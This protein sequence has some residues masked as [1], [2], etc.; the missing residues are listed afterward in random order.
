MAGEEILDDAEFWAAMRREMEGTMGQVAPDVLAEMAR[1]MARAGLD[2]EFDVADVNVQA[3][4]RSYIDAWWEAIETTT[5]ED[6]RAAFDAF[7]SGELGDREALIERLGSIFGEDR[8]AMIAAT[9]TTRLWTEGARVTMG[10][11]GVERWQYNTVND[12][13]VDEECSQYDG[14]VFDVDDDGAPWPPLHPNCRCF[15]SPVAA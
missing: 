2:V 10:I 7:A 4:I 13:Y 14:S 8:A 11:N 9:E 12:P 15:P 5:R 6:M 1:Q 3:V